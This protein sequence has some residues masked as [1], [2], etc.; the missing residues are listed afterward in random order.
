MLKGYSTDVP[1]SVT[2]AGR[3]GQTAARSTPPAPVGPPPRRA[4]HRWGEALLAAALLLPNLA[5]LIVF[6]YHPLID[7]IRLSFTDWNIS[8]PIANGVGVSN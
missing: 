4:G 2:S 8:S 7:N 1:S 5:L 3:V 6:T